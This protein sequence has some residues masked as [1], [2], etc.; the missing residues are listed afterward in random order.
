MIKRKLK[1]APPEYSTTVP[2][3]FRR[4]DYS[5]ARF[6]E[7]LKEFLDKY[8]DGAFRFDS[9]ENRGRFFSVS[10]KGIC[11][12]L[13]VIFESVYAREMIYVDVSLDYKHYTILLSFD[14]ALIDADTAARLDSI[15]EESGFDLLN[16]TSSLSLRI[17]LKIATCLNLYA[18]AE[19]RIYNT[20]SYVFFEI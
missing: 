19:K 9:T 5:S 12:A 15:A 6:T 8:Y 18:G 20:L 16:N 3:D 14:T 10:L 1:T 7:E 17:P 11:Y 13:R 4:A 2:A